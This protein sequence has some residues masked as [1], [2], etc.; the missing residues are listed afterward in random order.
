LHGQQKRCGAPSQP[1]GGAIRER[2]E[3]RALTR[4][5]P[6]HPPPRA[7]TLPTLRTTA[8]APAGDELASKKPETAAAATAAA[9]PTPTR[10]RA[11]LLSA[12]TRFKTPLEDDTPLCGAN[13]KNYNGPPFA[14]LQLDTP[15]YQTALLLLPPTNIT[16]L[17]GCNAGAT[18]DIAI[19]SSNEYTTYADAEL[20]HLRGD[21]LSATN[22][23]LPRLHAAPVPESLLT[24]PAATTLARALE[25]PTMMFSYVAVARTSPTFGNKPTAPGR[26]TITL[27]G[28]NALLKAWSPHAVNYLNTWTLQTIEK[29]SLVAI[30]G[31]TYTGA[32]AR[33]PQTL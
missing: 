30:Y 32:C 6:S 19:D 4:P 13:T 9:A 11:T 23:I 24:T 1:A 15:P 22:D 7:P 16:K 31:A 28:T 5:A 12:V 2:P 27:G 10:V 14:L 8:S 17:I 25:H 3:A 33:R 21:I 20:P 29:P 18:L 26:S